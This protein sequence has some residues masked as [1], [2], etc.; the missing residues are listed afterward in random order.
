PEEI[1]H[2]AL[3]DGA[4]L[5]GTPAQV[6]EKLDSFF[7]D[8]ACTDF[9]LS[10]HFAGLPPEKSSRSNELFAREVMPQFRNR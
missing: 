5:I 1:R 4:V 10:S 6:A 2:S 7:N 3:A 9:I 8:F